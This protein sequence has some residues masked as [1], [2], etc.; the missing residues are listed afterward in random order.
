MKFKFDLLPDEYKSLPRD[1]LGIALAVLTIIASIS[2]VG[3]MYIKNNSALQAVQVQ[4]DQQDNQLRDLID[5]T[6]KLQPPM[7]EINSLKNSINFINQ[8]LDTPGT[9]WVDFLATLES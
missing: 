5:K 2:A 3:T 7:N 4:V 9:S 8:N 6:G 1:N